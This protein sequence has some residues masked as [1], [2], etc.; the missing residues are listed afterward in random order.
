MV[1]LFS[2]NKKVTLL[3]LFLISSFSQLLKKKITQFK[4]RK[5]KSLQN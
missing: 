1:H 2:I 5:W 4:A 3:I